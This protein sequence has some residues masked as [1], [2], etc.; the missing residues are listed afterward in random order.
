M[1]IGGDQAMTTAGVA[2]RT[3]ADAAHQARVRM[4]AFLHT[5][6]RDLGLPTTALV[7]VADDGTSARDIAA[8]LGLPLERIEGLFLNSNL[9]G[10]DTLVRP[11]DRVAFVPYGTPA[12]HPSFFGPFDTRS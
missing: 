5:W 3:G 1:T 2:E 12:S 9:A 10:I 6:Q 4:L 11:G 7:D 8:E